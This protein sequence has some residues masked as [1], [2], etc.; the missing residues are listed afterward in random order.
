MAQ[1]VQRI[2]AYA[3]VVRDGEILLSRLAARLTTQ[4][5]WTLP[6][7]GVEHG[8]DPRDAVVREVHEETGLPVTVEDVARTYS[9]H[10]PHA[11]R[12]GRRVDAHSVRIVFRGWV[13]RDAEEP[14]V[15]EVDGSTSE[16]AW[17]PLSGVLDGSV[18][19]VGLVREA[20]ADYRPFEHHRV[21]AYGVALRPGPSGEEVLLTRISARGAHPGSWTLPGGGVAHGETPSDAL[22]REVREETGLDATTGAVLT[23]VDDHVHGTAPNGRDEQLHTVGLVY[24]VAVGDGEPVV[25]EPDGTTDRAAWVPVTDVEARR[26]EVLPLVRAALA[27]VGQHA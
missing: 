10:T 9:L 11:R 14:H 18:P 22:A 8:E 21:A 19:T 12:R 6:G 25:A 5:R 16:A 4:E 24:A 7:G 23:V 27:A 13:P 20:L 2:G 17:K 26:V 3:V 15:V 1:Q